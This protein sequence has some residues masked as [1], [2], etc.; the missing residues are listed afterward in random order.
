[1]ILN[2][3]NNNNNRK[4]YTVNPPITWWVRTMLYG[5]R[6]VRNSNLTVQTRI[7]RNSL[8]RNRAIRF[9]EL[10]QITSFVTRYIGDLSQFQYFSESTVL[11]RI[12]TGIFIN[13][14]FVY[15]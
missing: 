10:V 11:Y 3:N 6:S 7:I 8:Y 2:A 15:L 13:S 4:R 14:I 1:M 5:N 9:P 12:Q